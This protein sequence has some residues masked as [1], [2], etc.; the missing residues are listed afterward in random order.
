MHKG[1]ATVESGS[2]GLQAL[3]LRV[4][5]AENPL[6]ASSSCGAEVIRLLGRK[7]GINTGE[8]LAIQEA[9]PPQDR[10]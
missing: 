1:E 7:W 5:V 6:P 3:Q 4:P 9:P 8:E 2:V 10:S